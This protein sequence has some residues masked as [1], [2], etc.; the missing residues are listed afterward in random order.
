MTDYTNRPTVA[1]P[2]SVSIQVCEKPDDPPPS[3]SRRDT[4]IDSVV[5]DG[6]VNY[7]STA[8]IIV[9]PGN[10][11]QPLPSGQSS[12][13]AQEYQEALFLRFVCILFLFGCCVLFSL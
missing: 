2:G 3:Y 4:V 5:A 13:L 9:E 10:S 11:T 8:T 12:D 7:G 1:K 6:I